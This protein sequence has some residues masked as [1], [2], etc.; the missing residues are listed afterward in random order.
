MAAEG[1]IKV[2]CRVRP[3]LPTE[4]DGGDKAGFLE[5]REGATVVAKQPLNGVATSGG[6]FKRLNFDFDD[7]FDTDT[8]QEEVFDR[9]ARSVVEGE[10]SCGLVGCPP[11]PVRSPVSDAAAHLALAFPPRR[12]NGRVPWHDLRIR[13]VR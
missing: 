3:L 4:R 7:V 12:C 11:W 2:Y 5:V 10:A 8:T 6:V 1:N 13:A 9:A